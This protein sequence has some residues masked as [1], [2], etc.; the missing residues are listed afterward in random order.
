[1]GYNGRLVL[2][3]FAISDIKPDSWKS[4]N[5]S[6]Q[7]TAT[8]YFGKIAAPPKGFAFPFAEVRTR[9]ESGRSAGNRSNMI[10]K[11]GLRLY[12]TVA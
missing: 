12:K 1:M 9:N 5:R 3:R 2:V 11:R 8:R 6:Q 7:T 10:S 4:S